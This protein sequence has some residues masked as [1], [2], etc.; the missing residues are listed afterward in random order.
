MLC[1]TAYMNQ[2]EVVQ[3]EEEPCA[4]GESAGVLIE[5]TA[6]DINV[7]PDKYNTGA[8]GE[9]TT[10]EIGTTVNGI[11]FKAASD[12]TRN[13]LDFAYRNTNIAG[14]ISFENYDFSAYSL[15]SYNEDKVD[16]QIKVV[17]NNCKFS[18]VA[19]GKEDGNLSFEFNNCTME[20]FN[21]S[22]SVFNN[23]LFSKGNT[24]GLVPFQ[25][26]A[27]NDCFFSDMA[28]KVASG[29]EIH[30]D[31][32]QI[33]GA[34]GI[35]VSNVSYDNC[36]FEIPPLSIE[37]STASINACIMLQIEYSNAK[38]VSFTDCIVNGGGYSIYAWDKNKGYTFENVYFDGIRSG[39]A[40]KFATLYGSVDAA[41]KMSDIGETDTLYVSSV[42]KENNETHF[43]VSNDTNKERTL[44]I[45]TD[46][47]E[48][49]YVIP[50]CP[51]GEEMTSSMTYDDMP[52]DLDIVVPEDCGY[53]ICYDGTIDGYSKQIRFVNWSGKSVYLD[54]N[55]VEEMT[56]KGEEV[57]FSGKCGSDIEFYLTKSG[58]LVLSGQGAT[59]GYHSTKQPLWTEY[60]DD[61]QE[62]RIEEGIEALGSQIF[63]NCS[64]VK[65]VI[66]PDTLTTIE[67]R[68]FSGCTS[69]TTITLPGSI[70]K[71]GDAVFTGTIL[72]EIRF[73]GEDWSAISLG[74][75]NDALADKVVYV[76]E[77]QENINDIIMQGMCGDQI[78]YV[79]T[80]DG[81]LRLTGRGATY[82]YH[83]AKTAPW[84]E[85]RE[86]VKVVVIEDGIEQ[87]GEQLFRKCSSMEKIQLPKTLHI[88]SRNA[89]IS[90]T[91]LQ[92]ITIPGS[93]KE[94][95]RF[96]FAGI[97]Y[98]YTTY[99]GT[100]EDWNKIEIGIC[101][102]SIQTNINFL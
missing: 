26:I 64:A 82:N 78:E 37:G 86:L 72:Q 28:C 15:W 11:Q 44:V 73:E 61:I 17:F 100:E 31:G 4:L 13:V 81:V 59:E 43:I 76:D 88:I 75:G 71:I 63:R 47:G 2:P 83:S 69:L 25:N 12:N 39:C 80:E 70:E 101:N 93:V 48:Y 32:T 23:C 20:G 90:C 94:I 33:Y 87:I 38:N 52:F 40:K 54:K 99:E 68:A 21:G 62:I 95:Q 6:A 3:I 60:I 57:V 51:Q 35:D 30:T 65:T 9:L 66:L 98:I 46:K 55:T 50:A 22:N 92:E 41:I 16:R 97:P 58:V 49:E 67:K 77:E 42:W 85:V 5:Q 19:V 56:S 89:F 8:K 102:E 27:V 14:T 79:L 96:A 29:K 34:E 36:R 45:Y 24:D 10:V 84:Y 74:S 91:G 53:A 18:T 1:A 7:I